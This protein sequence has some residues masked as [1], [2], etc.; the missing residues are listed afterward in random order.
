[1]LSLESR[2]QLSEGLSV[3]DLGS[4]FRS[5]LL[6]EKRLT[7]QKLKYKHEPRTISTLHRCMHRLRR[8]V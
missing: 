8:R 2:F 5:F 1:M 6:A 7:K 3:K 4:L